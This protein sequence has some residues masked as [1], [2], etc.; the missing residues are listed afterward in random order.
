MQADAQKTARFPLRPIT[1]FGPASEL[2]EY[3]RSRTPGRATRVASARRRT[4]PPTKEA[5]QLA[6]SALAAL[7]LVLVVLIVLVP[8]LAHEMSHES[9]A[10]VVP[11][12]HAAG[13]QETQ[14]PAVITVLVLI[15]VILVAAFIIILVFVRTPLAQEAREH[16]ATN[17]ASAQQAAR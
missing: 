5:H 4:R 9:T 14:Y 1:R 16:K 2:L 6:L 8:A 13:D 7:V 11:P 10:E 15:F 17:A 12:Q 3:S